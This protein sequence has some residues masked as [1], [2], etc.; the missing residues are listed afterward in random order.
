MPLKPPAANFSTLPLHI[1][2]VAVTSLRR[3]GRH[4]SG[5]PYFGKNDVFRFDDPNKVFGTCYC[6]IHLDTAIAETVLHDEIPD[7]GHFRIHEDVIASRHLVRFEETSSKAKLKLADLRGAYL[8]RLGGDN[9]LSAEYPYDVTKLWGV[10]V[11][12]HPKLVDGF[13][14]VSKQL[15]T[16]PAIVLFDRAAKKFGTASYEPLGS[17]KGFTQAAKRLGMV[18]YGSTAISGATTP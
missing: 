17:V 10:A 14:F 4:T 12:A 3:V 7:N 9:Y 5:E 13:C 16:K 11:H 18:I 8:K 2:A 15:N 1:K 6:G